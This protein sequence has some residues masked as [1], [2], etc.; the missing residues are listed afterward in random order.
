MYM[1]NILT[2]LEESYVTRIIEIV[3]REITFIGA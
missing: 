1:L 2:M 3:P